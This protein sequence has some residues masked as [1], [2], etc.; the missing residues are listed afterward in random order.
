[1]WH[2]NKV[3][4]RTASIL[5][6]T[7]R[8]RASWRKLDLETLA[9]VWHLYRGG[10]TDPAKIQSLIKQK[11]HSQSIAGIVACLD[12]MRAGPLSLLSPVRCRNCGGKLL[13]IPCRV[14]G[15]AGESYRIIEV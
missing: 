7:P 13:D 6:A 9:T 1:M 8:P 5:N 15:D 11:V 10:V 2:K 4:A 12:R 14:C 3:A